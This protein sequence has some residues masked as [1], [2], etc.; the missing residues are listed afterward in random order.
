MKSGTNWLGSLLSSHE[1]IS[2]VGEF[3]WESLA[4]P[5]NQ[6][7]QNHSVLDTPAKKGAARKEFQDFVKKCLR[8]VAE[9]TATLI[10]DRTPHTIGPVILKD[11]PHI[12]I[13]RDGRDVLVSRVFHL[14]NNAGIHRLFD[15]IPEMREDQE[16]FAKNPWYFNENPGMLLR[17]ELMVRQSVRWWRNH[18]ESDRNTLEKHTYLPVKFVKYEELH[19][20]TLKQRN[21]LFEFLEVNPKRAAKLAGVLKPGFSEENPQ[22]FFRKGSVGDWKNYFGDDTRKWFKEEAGEELITQGYENSLDW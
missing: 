10:G 3:H 22:D 1:S 2:V 21:Q 7:L 11:A 4:E 19:A 8:D 18:L 9:P 6:F 14:Y 17:H 13:V 16:N 20:D 15:R 5:F 12:S